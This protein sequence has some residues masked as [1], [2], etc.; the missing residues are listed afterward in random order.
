MMAAGSVASAASFLVNFSGDET[1]KILYS[2]AG[3]IPASGTV[4]LIDAVGSLVAPD[5]N[6]GHVTETVT[7]LMAPIPGVIDNLFHFKGAPGVPAALFDGQGV[8]MNYTSTAG[9]GINAVYATNY[10]VG[11]TADFGFVDTG[12]GASGQIQV[13]VPEPSAWTMMIVGFGFAGGFVRL[14]RRSATL[15]ATA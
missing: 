9:N 10:N 4:T 12:T 14:R 13:A 8:G 1:G 15:V 3:S 2:Y 5:G 11:G 7:G 6:G